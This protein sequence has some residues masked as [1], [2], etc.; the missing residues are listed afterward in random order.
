MIF[1]KVFLRVH[2]R[3]TF[4]FCLAPT[5]KTNYSS[6]IIILRREKTPENGVG[7]EINS[8]INFGGHGEATESRSFGSGR[9]AEEL[10][11]HQ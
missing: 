8:C 6:P 11:V 7:K 1:P 3:Y 4:V 9:G 10:V 5:Q 2:Q